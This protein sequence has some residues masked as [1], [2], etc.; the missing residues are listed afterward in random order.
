MEKLS[1]NMIWMA[2]SNLVSSFFNI[3]VFIYLARVL[4]PD[5]FGYLSYAF[6]LIFFLTNF[7]DLGLSTYGIREIAKDKSRAS[8][9]ISEIVSFRT[10]IVALLIILTVLTISLSSH[11]LVRRTLILESLFILFACGIAVEWA[12]QGLENARMVFISFSVTPIL[13]FLLIFLFVRNP[14]DLLKVPV[15]YFLAML[16][17]PLAF[18]RIFK[19][20][21]SMNREDFKRMT[22][23][24]A[25][26][27]TI[28]SISIFAQVYNGFDIFILGFFRPMDDVGYF[29][30]ARRVIGGATMLMIFLANAVL[31]R[32][33]HV[34]GN[35]MA[36]FKSATRKFLNAIIILTIFIFLPITIFSKELIAITVGD[37]YLP[38][39]LSLKIMF[40][41]L[42]LV[43]FNLPYSTGL[44]AC[45]LEKEVLKQAIGCAVASIILN[46]ILIPKYGMIGASISF[47]IV[48]AIA[49]GWILWAYK[50]SLIK[51]KE[52]GGELNDREK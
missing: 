6:T 49:L 13:Q 25:S 33:S 7:I 10:V 11:A 27:L 39:A 1:K 52:G 46:L 44:I 9:Y 15:L 50:V 29:T 34:V 28:W 31:P 20:R 24:L 23:Y 35:D 19:F 43:L 14:N 40:A 22:G 4:M 21:P 32:L 18:L 37:K 3:V 41:G 2:A 30:I 12:F 8:L 38:A 5:N 51:I 36:Q 42:I 47:V 48:E 45:R 17:V 16:P 26:S